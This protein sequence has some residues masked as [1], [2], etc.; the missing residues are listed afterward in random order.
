[1]L[2]TLTISAEQVSFGYQYLPFVI[3]TVL[4]STVRLSVL[5]FWHTVNL[6]VCALIETRLA[7][8]ERCVFEEHKV[9]FYKPVQLPIHRQECIEDEIVSS[10]YP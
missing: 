7:Q 5:S 3:L 4:K 6:A 10:H 2:D 1:M 9:Y 8:N